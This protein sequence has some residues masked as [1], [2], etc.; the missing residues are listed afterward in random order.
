MGQAVV[1]YEVAIHAHLVRIILASIH[2]I[3]ITNLNEIVLQKNTTHIE[4]M[5]H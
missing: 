4:Y 5:Y 2:I 3:I 1:N